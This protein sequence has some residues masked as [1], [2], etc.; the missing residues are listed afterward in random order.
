MNDSGFVSHCLELLAP[1]GRT[2]SRRM[3]GGHALYIDGLCMALIIQD[4][5]YLKVDDTSRTLLEREGC[6]PFTYGTKTG[7]RHALGYY[8][9]P[10]AAMESPA[11]MMPWARRALAAAVG[12]R[13]KAPARKK[14]AAKAPTTKPT[15]AKSAAK[16]IATGTAAVKKT[17]AKK[18]APAKAAAAKSPARKVAP[19]KK[20][21]A[22]TATKKAA[23]A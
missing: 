6:R 7:E 3:F 16:K 23:R 12:A 8:T 22:K 14:V 11:E 13:A 5:L 4:T 9:A 18:A 21:A 19:A 10:E 1:L 15:V 20:A 2:S 17:P